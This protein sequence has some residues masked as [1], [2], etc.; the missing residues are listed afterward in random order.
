MIRPLVPFCLIVLLSGHS[1]ASAS[2]QSA[3]ACGSGVVRSI[4]AID[5]T[6][7]RQT[8]ATQRGNDGGVEA[9]VVGTDIEHRRAY[10]LAVQLGGVLYT[11]ESAGDPH[12]T[13]DPMRLVAGEPI[14]MCV[15]ATQMIVET[16]NGSDYRAPIVRRATPPARPCSGSIRR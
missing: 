2:A 10:V 6:V 8:T 9:V 12:G 11:S 5:Y 14:Q 7:T 16:P 13:L 1:P 15:S 4:E 3:W